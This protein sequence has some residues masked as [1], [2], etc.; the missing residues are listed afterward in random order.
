MEVGNVAS[1]KRRRVETVRKPFLAG[2]TVIRFLCVALLVLNL[3]LVSS[4]FFSSNGIWGYRLKSVQV[5]EIEARINA[6]QR[7]NQRMYRKIMHFKTDRRAQERLAREQ[8]G[9][10]K[11][12]ELVIEFHTPRDGT[13]SRSSGEGLPPNTP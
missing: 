10:V 5:K 13:L 11:K 6:L 1:G 8:L 7:D 12:D 2:F 9:W 3:L 4:I